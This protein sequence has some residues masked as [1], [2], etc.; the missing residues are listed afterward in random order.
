M[1]SD[2]IRET[3][4]DCDGSKVKAGMTCRMCKGTGEI[5]TT[6]LVPKA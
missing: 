3:C 6:P 5:T 2:Q 1:S 4:W